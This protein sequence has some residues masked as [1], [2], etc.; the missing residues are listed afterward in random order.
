MLWWDGAQEFRDVM[1]GGFCL[2]SGFLL[3]VVKVDLLARKIETKCSKLVFFPFLT[4]VSFAD[5]I[6]SVVV[7]IKYNK[8][9]TVFI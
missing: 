1:W 7:G 9:C 8:F 3:E 4:L 5:I 2:C 6:V